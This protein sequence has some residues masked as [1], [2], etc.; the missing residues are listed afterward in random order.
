M[1]RF[2][3][4]LF[5]TIIT[6]AIYFSI[7]SKNFNYNK[8]VNLCNDKIE[9]PKVAENCLYNLLK[10]SIDNRDYNKVTDIIE[11]GHK[12]K[13]YSQT[14]YELCHSNSHKL[15]FYIQNKYGFDIK[16]GEMLFSKNCNQGIAH[17]FFESLDNKNY[18]T[19]KLSNLLAFCNTNEYYL[20]CGH[21]YGHFLS[22]IDNSNFIF[23]KCVTYQ[24]L[25]DFIPEFRY[26]CGYGIAM[27]LWSPADLVS[28]E[29][30]Q[31]KITLL[32]DN[33]KNSI[34]YNLC[35]NIMDPQVS[36]GCS[37]GLGFSYKEYLSIES[38]KNS[39]NELNELINFI[40][41]SVVRE[42]TLLLDKIILF[43]SKLPNNKVLSSNTLLQLKKLICIDDKICFDKFNN[44]LYKNLPSELIPLYCNLDNP[45]KY[46]ASSY[47]TNRDKSIYYDDNLSN[48]FI[49]CG[50][51]TKGIEDCQSQ[52]FLNFKNLYYVNEEQYKDLLKYYKL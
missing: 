18:P 5:L 16:N 47:S 41:N 13:L 44:Y 51:L 38:Y 1:K 24:N 28:K 20:G 48:Y 40:S 36:K 42:N 39:Y 2:F 45:S 29:I 21:G 15:G 14:F 52:L 7:S 35:N 50:K 26:E 11:L 9:I 32:R 25:I 34:L 31:N 46:C 3:I 4:I 19:K 49:I 33:L 22:L 30:D 6:L 27:S 23:D 8:A 43:Y 37:A 10:S 12:N 17:G